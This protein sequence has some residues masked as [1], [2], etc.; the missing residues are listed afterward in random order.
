MLL[1]FV[2]VQQNVQS[3]KV[4]CDPTPSINKTCLKFDVS[5][6]PSYYYTDARIDIIALKVYPLNCSRHDMTELF[7]VQ[8]Q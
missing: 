6:N 1:L 8:Q 7:D 2:C 3:H 5:S 4:G